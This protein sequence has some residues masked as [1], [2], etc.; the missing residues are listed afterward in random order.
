LV[1]SNLFHLFLLN[2]FQHL[3]GVIFI[4][5]FFFRNLIITFGSGRLL[6]EWK[7]IFIFYFLL[8][9]PSVFLSFLFFSPFFAFA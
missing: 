8:S 2:R 3:K 4:H 6:W 1:E 9:L 7:G 5:F